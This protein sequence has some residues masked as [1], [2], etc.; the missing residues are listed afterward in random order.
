M[1]DNLRWRRQLEVLQPDCD[2]GPHVRTADPS[3]RR[4]PNATSVM[5][6][7]SPSAPRQAMVAAMPDVRCHQAGLLMFYEDRRGPGR[8]RC[9][10]TSGGPRS[11]RTLTGEGSV[12]RR[13][14]RPKRVVLTEATVSAAGAWATKASAKLEGREIPAGHQRMDA[15]ADYLA[16][17]RQPPVMQPDWHRRPSDGCCSP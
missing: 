17:Q 12:T 15:A 10:R 9:A 4:K 5:F 6:S 14:S 11:W 8:P 7:A 3:A 16:R 2:C 13:A 1:S